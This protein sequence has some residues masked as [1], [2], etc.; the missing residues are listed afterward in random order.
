AISQMR[1]GQDN[2]EAIEGLY[3]RGGTTEAVVRQARRS[4]EQDQIAVARAELTLRTWQL[5]EDEIE[6]VKREA[7]RV[8]ARKGERDKEKEKDWARVDL[9]ARDRKSVV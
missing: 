5:P 1:L 6:D 7:E 4:V 8:I 3:K 9:K 2:L